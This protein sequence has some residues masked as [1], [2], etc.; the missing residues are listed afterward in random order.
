MNAIKRA[1][2][3]LS[4]LLAGLPISL[5]APKATPEEQTVTFLW[6]AS[7]STAETTEL[8]YNVVEDAY[9][10]RITFKRDKTFKGSDGMGGLWSFEGGKLV[11]TALDAKD[12]FTI[13]FDPPT[14]NSQQLTGIVTSKGRW[15]GRHIVLKASPK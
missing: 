11:L 8:I 12:G 7:G 4:V 10:T 5:A 2:A 9:N 13:K 15:H 3:L 14:S 1:T 6:S